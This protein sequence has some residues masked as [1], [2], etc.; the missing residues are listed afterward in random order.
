MESN[1]NIIIDYAI[2]ALF[3]HSL[4]CWVSFSGFAEVMFEC[5][6]DTK[7]AQDRYQLLSGYLYTLSIL[8]Y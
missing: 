6:H 8:K 3:I 2:F 1:V 5:W 7:Y 4:H